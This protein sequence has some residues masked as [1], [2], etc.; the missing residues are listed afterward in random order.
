MGMR[1]ELLRLPSLQLAPHLL[2]AHVSS[3]IGGRLV[4]NELL[5]TSWNGPTYEGLFL[6][7]GGVVEITN[8]RDVQWTFIQ[9]Q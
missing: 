7:S 9:E 3:F 5:G 8:S 6:T 2:G 4:V 1:D